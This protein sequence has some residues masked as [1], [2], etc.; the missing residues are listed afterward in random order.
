MNKIAN[1]FTVV[2]AFVAV[3]TFSACTK[4]FDYPPAATDP[5]IVANTSVA[6]LKALHTVAAA[7][8]VINDDIVVSGVIVANDQS[9]N[10]YKQLFIQDATGSIQL[11]LDASSLYGNYPVGRKVYIKCKGL[12]L[13]DYHG[14]MQL[15]IKALVAGATSIQ[16]IPGAL[17]SQYLIGGSLNNPVVPIVV[18]LDQLG[19]GMQDRYMGALIQLN[20]FEFADTTATY[21]DTSAYKNT[22]N[23]DIKNCDGAS[24]LI[25]TSG[26][27][28]FAANKLAKGQGSIS[29][30]YTV[31]G[32]T[33]QFIIRDES[34]V[35]FD[36]PRCS[37]FEEGF[38]A[39]GANST[40]FVLNGW[41]NIAEV[42]TV[43]YQN[44]IFGSVKCVKVSAYKAGTTIPN[45]TSWLISPAIALKGVANPKLSFTTG[46]GYISSA[47]PGFSVYISTTYTGNNTPSTA[48]TTKLNAVMAVPPASG[49]SPFLSSGNIDL[50]AYVGQTIYL[51][52]KYE[53][54]DPTKTATYELDDVR[55]LR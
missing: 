55:I 52:W 49:F 34:D 54:S 11:M 46:A 43:T 33:K 35:K 1:Y 5:S 2:L 40:T 38:D 48:F 37:I 28:S 51:A 45:T 18:T 25:R 16:G 9:G 15:G 19:T 21:S 42:G 17:I 6:D 32:T 7:L 10:F 36:N 30:I 20:N 39:I 44:A 26:Y 27:A 24:S 22:T 12:C 50:T 31:Y 53:G 8:D 41:K 14:T 13:S 4:T 23:R 3:A 29:A 47:T